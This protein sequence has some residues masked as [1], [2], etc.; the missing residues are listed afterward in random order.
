MT[1]VDEV[2][3]LPT[4]EL[5]PGQRTEVWIVDALGGAPELVYS[6][7]R[8]AARGA[9]LG[10]RRRRAA[11]QRP[12]IA[13]AADARAGRRPSTRSIDRRPAADQQRPR[14]STRRAT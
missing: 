5:G 10:A 14:A 8:T 11:A 4:R 2:Q 13:V 6:Q 1:A 9:Q 3:L 12:R 7:R